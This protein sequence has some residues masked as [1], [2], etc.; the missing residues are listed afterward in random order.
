[1]SIVLADHHYRPFLQIKPANDRRV[2]DYYQDAIFDCS[3][4]LP[5]SVHE[6]VAAFWEWNPN[7]QL[8]T[9][10][11]DRSFRH[12]AAGARFDDSLAVCV[13]DADATSLS[14]HEQLDRLRW[15]SDLQ[16]AVPDLADRTRSRL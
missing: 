6:S 11:L 16:Y 10:Q 5:R 15:D 2:N 13:T 1:L 7:D 8:F 12:V 3:A 4:E 14:K 9:N